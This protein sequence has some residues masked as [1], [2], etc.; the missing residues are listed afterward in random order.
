MQLASE[1]VRI[2]LEGQYTSIHILFADFISNA[3]NRPTVEKF[4]PIDPTALSTKPPGAPDTASRYNETI[5]FLL[6][7]S[8]AAVFQALVPKYLNSRLM[9]LFAE[10]FTSEHAARMMAMNNATS[11]SEERINALTLKLNKMRQASITKE[12]LEIVG[13]AEALK[14]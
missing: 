6:E 10:T 13:G 5:S 12:M 9:I 7:P 11:N 8:P 4:L 1:L 14:G 2:F 3:L